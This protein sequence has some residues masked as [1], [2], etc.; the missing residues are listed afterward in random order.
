[1]LKQK[2][3]NFK[4]SFISHFSSIYSS[5]DQMTLTTTDSTFQHVNSTEKYIHYAFIILISLILLSILAYI[6]IT[7]IK[8][9][10]KRKFDIIQ[11]PTITDMTSE[12]TPSYISTRLL[13]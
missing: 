3:N 4:R 8:Q 7:C 11:S 6:F 10:Q 13:K 12:N 2:T 9:H 5:N 1:M